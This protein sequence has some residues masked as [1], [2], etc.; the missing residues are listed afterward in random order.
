MIGATSSRTWM[1]ARCACTCARPRARASKRPSR[2]SRAS[3][4]RSGSIVPADEIE[5]ILD[6]IG[7]PTSGINLAFGDSATIGSR[8]RRDPDLAEGEARIR[9]ANT[10]ASCA[11]CCDE[12]F[13]EE[14]FFFPAGEYHQPDSELRPARA[15]R[16]AG[17]RAAIRQANYEVA[18]RD[19]ATACAAFPGAVDVHIHQ[20]VELSRDRCERGP[21]QGA[22]SSA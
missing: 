15:D 2:S 19:R 21:Q 7:L 14:T 12:K 8:G 11:R 10:C 1:P 16:R 13:P 17:G 22:A 18:R 5:L 3:R 20:E 4:T 6:N 9:R